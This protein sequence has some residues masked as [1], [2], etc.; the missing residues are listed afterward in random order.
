M[1]YQFAVG[2]RKNAVVTVKLFKGKDKSTVNSIPV[3]EY[4]PTDFDLKALI[5]PIETVNLVDKVYYVAKATSG[6]KKGQVGALI[7][8]MSRALI[9]LDPELRPSLKKLGFLSRDDRMVERKKTGQP[10]ARKK[11]QYSKR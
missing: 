6:G 1:E 2:R 9:K 5:K 11:P 10:K 7:L 4:F 8:A 3:S